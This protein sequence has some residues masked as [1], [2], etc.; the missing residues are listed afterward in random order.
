MVLLY[1]LHSLVVGCF[2]IMA[3]LFSEPFTGTNSDVVQFVR[4]L[5]IWALQAGKSDADVVMMV[6][7]LL[8]GPALDWYV[9]L[10]PIE[11]KNYWARLQQ[12][13]LTQFRKTETLEAIWKDIRRVRQGYE[14]DIRDFIRRFEDLYRRLE[15]LGNNQVPPDF[16]K[17]DQFIVAL[18]ED[19]KQFR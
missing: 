6:S 17:R 8:D 4:R 3:D 5:K 16:M 10:V 14:E 9:R 7:L 1:L 18:H 2:K 13:L 19:I 11:A 15:R 12:A